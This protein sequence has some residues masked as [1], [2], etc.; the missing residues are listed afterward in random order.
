MLFKLTQQR[1]DDAG[2]VWQM[3][4][5]QNDKYGAGVSGEVS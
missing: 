2:E 4:L 3:R 5:L 1:A